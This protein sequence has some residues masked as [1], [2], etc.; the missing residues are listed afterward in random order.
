MSCA[1]LHG[2]YY[3][4][5]CLRFYRLDYLKE[6]GFL[7]DEG[8]I[9]EDESFS[10]LAYI[11]AERVEC[12]GEKYYLRRYRPGSIMMNRD[13]YKSAHGYSVAISTLLQYMQKKTLNPSEEK[14][15]NDQIKG[16]I[17]SIYA[18]YKEVKRKP[19]DGL[20]YDHKTYSSRIVADTQGV[21]KQVCWN[22]EG[23]PLYYRLICN[24]FILGYHFWIM[25]EKMRFVY[26]FIKRN[27]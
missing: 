13:P 9:H 2:E 27:K 22:A 12:L 4:Q 24:N 21:I 25:R 10:F 8:I 1:I 5:A 11:N 19:L 23:F 15:F 6:N 20:M 26:S 18:R 16:Y 3:S 7:F 14:L 17:F